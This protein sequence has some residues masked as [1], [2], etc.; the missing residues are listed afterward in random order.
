M[1]LELHTGIVSWWAAKSFNFSFH[2]ILQ[3]GH[4]NERKIVKL[5]EY[6]AKNPFRIP[7]VVAFWILMCKHLHMHIV[8]KFLCIS[9]VKLIY[10]SNALLP[11]SVH[12]RLPN[13]LKK[14]VTKSCEMG[15]SKLLEL[16]LRPITNCSACV[17]SRCKELIL[18]MWSC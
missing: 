10:A 3:E 1:Y 15:I 5:C 7:K 6:A 11:F 16:L 9:W 2:S 17:R 14:G 8:S 4:P 12:T 13:I 18:F